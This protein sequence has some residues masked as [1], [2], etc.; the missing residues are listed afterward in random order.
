MLCTFQG[1]RVGSNEL[2]L[3]GKSILDKLYICG[4][5]FYVYGTIFC[6]QAYWPPL[7]CSER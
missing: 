3:N 4:G 6:S 1:G 7:F 2:C 5:R